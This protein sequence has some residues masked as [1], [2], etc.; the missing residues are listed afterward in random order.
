MFDENQ[1][2]VAA[3][4]SVSGRPAQAL[5]LSLTRYFNISPALRGTLVAF[6]DYI[7]YLIFAGLVWAGVV[8]R[9]LS[10]RLLA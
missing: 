6:A 10:H 7:G 3:G 5:A 1:D 9:R 8:H 4:L 2:V